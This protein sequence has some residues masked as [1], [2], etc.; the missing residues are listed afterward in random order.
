MSED[1]WEA[2]LGRV[3]ECLKTEGVLIRAGEVPSKYGMTRPPVYFVDART[4]EAPT[5]EEDNDDGNP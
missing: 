2:R 3:R 5:V 4:D 1:T